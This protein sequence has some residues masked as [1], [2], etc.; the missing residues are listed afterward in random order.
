MKEIDFNSIDD[1]QEYQRLSTGGYICK[2]TAVEDEPQKEYL[3]L[4]YDIAQGDFKDYYKNLFTA[5][6]FWGGSF[7]RSYKANALPFFKAFKTAVENSNKKNKFAWTSDEQKLVGR[8]VG[9]VLSEEEYKAQDGSMKTRLY[10]SDVRSAQS[11]LDG[12]FKVLE[13]KKYID[14]KV[15][16]SN[17][18]QIITE[19]VEEELPF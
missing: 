4:E 8:Y 9:L 16:K 3:K 13:L 19:V 6:G 7:Y 14:S 18:F 15:T 5:K 10:V 11:I 1:V 12:D 17:A 2:I